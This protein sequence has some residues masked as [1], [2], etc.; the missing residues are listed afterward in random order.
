MRSNVVV[1]H[2]ERLCL[3]VIAGCA[4][5]ATSDAGAQTSTGSIRGY[6]SD[7]S[8]APIADAQVQAQNTGTGARRA[9]QTNAAGFYAL[10]GLT[11]GEWEVTARRLGSAP[12]AR[13]LP[14]G[15]GQSLSIDFR[16]APST[17]ELAQVTV[18]AEPTAETRTSEIATN[19]TRQQIEDLPSSDRNFLTLAALAP[20]VS[21][22]N[23]RIDGTRKTFSA[24]AQ[25]ADQVNVFIDGASYKND[26]LQGGVAGQDASRGS[27]FPRSA[28]QEFRILTQNYKAEYQ[29]ASSAIIT[30]ATKSGG[31]TWAGNAFLTVQDKK[32]I[33]LDSLQGLDRRNNANFVKPDYQ[34]YQFGLSGGGPIT[35]RLK[36]FGS[37]ER[38]KQDRAVRVNI[39]PPAAPALDT[40]DFASRN[41][42][43]N[44]PFQ[45]NLIFGKL[46]FEHNPNSTID[47]SVNARDEEDIRDFDV[48]RSFES[49]TLFKNHVYTG[50]LKHSYFRDAWLNEGIISYQD[51]N[52]N[53]VANSPGV[54]QRQ[55]G[56][57]CC[58]QIGSHISEQD[59]T[60]K[61]LSFRDDLTFTG[62]KWMGEHVVKGGANIDFLDYD[63]IKRNN[64]N[65]KF[66]YEPWFFNFSIPEHVEFQTGDPN[67][68]D[69][70]RQ[71]GAYLQDDWSPTPRLTLNVGVRWDYESKMMNYDYVTPR[72]IVDSLVKY[73]SRLFIP[74]D[75]DRYFTDG[76]NRDPFYGAFQP[77]LGASYEVDS[78]GRTTLFGGFGLFYDRTLYDHAL[79]E[80]FA[81]Q[82]PSFLV[83]FKPVGDADP[84]RIEFQ[85]R[86]LTQAGIDELKASQAARTPEV[87]LLPNDMK[88]PMSKQFTFGVRQLLGEF[89][90][91]A[92]YTGVR[93]D[94]QFT[95]YFANM[96]FTCTPR[97]FACFRENRIPGYSTIL[98]GDDRGKTWYDALALKV[99]RSYRKVANVGWGAGLAYTL[100]KRQTEGF[101]DL[102]SFPNPADYPKQV[103]N[104]ERHRVVSNFIVDV[105]YVFGIQLSGLVTLG[106]GTNYDRGDRF[107]PT[108]LQAGAGKPERSSF[109]IPG[110][111]LWAYR[112]VD[113]RVRKDFPPFGNT[114]LGVTAD[115]F[116]LF[117]YQNLGCYSNQPDPEAGDFA[118]ARCVVSDARRLQV[119]MEYDF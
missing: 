113:L 108:G 48:N 12:Q 94:N 74:L 8:G 54:F 100:A 9:A 58:V 7:P 80:R 25:G 1:R 76:S 118:V 77:R 103:R 70:N 55:F 22:Q 102:F 14:V 15:I 17:V 89:A 50:T 37:F 57:G 68:S 5:V 111:D 30:A 91:E 93:S 23:D 71:V 75:R 56:F 69:K 101:N 112:M 33:A 119:G 35:E 107:A 28:V 110:A 43:F 26:I 62:F 4:L 41:G 47:F 59:F 97:T 6:V 114:R 84:N 10:P 66:Y 82:H 21:L 64:E 92:A 116:N 90:V 40:I 53:P 117:N 49:A 52:Y 38:I 34:K 79:E 67:F 16:L 11:P 99:D 27:P 18:V 83:R 65:P 36:V 98:F 88:P 61:R 44:S 105:P 2:L 19:V 20:G 73:E 109:I 86:Y 72:A 104:D 63:V 81:L 78:R 85:D 39:N 96:N 51:Y 60:Q 31:T 13:R 24:G 29:K 32:W 106:S 42:S 45:S 87:K 115:V 46:T 95:F 3:A